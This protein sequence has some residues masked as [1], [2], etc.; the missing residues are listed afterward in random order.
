MASNSG[1][2]KI[3]IFPDISNMWNFPNFIKGSKLLG[4]KITF[5]IILL[6]WLKKHIKIQDV[7]KHIDVMSEKTLHH[8]DSE[9]INS[10][11]DRFLA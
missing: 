9:N 10:I 4:I 2:L 6:R 11:S 3:C 1:C 5:F 8:N 7:T